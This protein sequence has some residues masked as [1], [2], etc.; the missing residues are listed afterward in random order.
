MEDVKRVQW[1]CR[2]DKENESVIAVNQED[3]I[4]NVL[5]VL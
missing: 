4:I 3:C 5:P 2:H 1:K